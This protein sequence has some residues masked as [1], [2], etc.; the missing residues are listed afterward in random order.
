MA[1]HERSRLF[2]NLDP[3]SFG[4]VAAD[5]AD[6]SA[7]PRRDGPK[8]PGA[9]RSGM[10]RRKKIKGKRSGL[11]DLQ[12]LEL[13]V[14]FKPLWDL[15]V[16]L[17][18]LTAPPPRT[19]GR[20]RVW[21]AFD[22]LLFEVLA[23]SL[24]SYEAVERNLKDPRIWNLLRSTVEA[25]WPQD[26]R[27]RLSA[28]SPTR[29]QHYR[30]RRR[31]LSDYLLGVMH[32]LIDAAAV[33]AAQSMGMLAPGLG[34]LTDPDPRSFVTADGCWVPA[35]TKLTR[36]DATDPYTG[37]IVGRYDPDAI[38]YRDSDGAI[39]ARGFLKVMVVC[40]NP[41]PQERV[42][43]TARLKSAHNPEVN[44][45][46]ATIAVDALLDL[47]ERVPSLRAGLRG[48]VYD[49]ALSDAD[50][51]RLMDAGLIPVEKVRRRNDG[52]PAAEA[53]GPHDFKTRQGH[54][55][56]L[57]VT[58]VTGTPCL[59]F[60]DGTGK[61]YYQPLKLRQV[62]KT[63]RKTRTQVATLWSIPDKG[64]VPP[65]LVGARVRIRH[66]R[67]KDEREAG[68][69]RS[70]ALRVFPDSDHRYGKL[71]GRREDSES[72]NADHKSRL[73]NGRCRTLRHLNV[74]FNNIAYQAHVMVTALAAHHKRTGANLTRWFGQHTI[75]T[76][77]PLAL[78][79]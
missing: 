41:H 22:M 46:D 43:L 52:S 59:T 63:K 79:A 61:R 16:Q 3:A 9:S 45:N 17:D 21:R 64:I 68:K 26:H 15:A 34:S 62:T 38:F 24:G 30:F 53:L 55:V 32:N 5:V 37:E 31:Y 20:K 12:F 76:A 40:R 27:M 44:Q 77:A 72:L 47:M 29:S 67:T 23:W 28:K 78:A 19:S 1:S 7:A 33:E 51:D 48:L 66:T 50:Y 71:F 54:K 56:T 57:D 42:V 60:V 69:S 25:A 65:H 74:E 6:S 75:A 8:P 10:S 11:S 14:C 49:M 70:R 4:A 58:A 13:M 18:A 2:D 36:T 39:R 73:W 35:L